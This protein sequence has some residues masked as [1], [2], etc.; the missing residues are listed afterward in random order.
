MSINLHL[1]ATSEQLHFLV[2][3]YGTSEFLLDIAYTESI[4]TFARDGGVWTDKSA[5]RSRL[6]ATLAL[7]EVICM[8]T[9]SIFFPHSPT[10]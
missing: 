3:V 1:R 6:D 2:F 4:S 8:D 5:G 7:N 10:C 9:Y